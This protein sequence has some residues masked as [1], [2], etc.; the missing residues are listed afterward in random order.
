MI[1][2]YD[3]VSDTV[4]IIMIYNTFHQE[5]DDIKESKLAY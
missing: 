5:E 1:Q 4:F 2:A 3:F